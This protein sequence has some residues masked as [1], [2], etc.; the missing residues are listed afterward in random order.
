M[1]RVHEFVTRTPFEPGDRLAIATDLP[2][3]DVAMLVASLV[4]Q[5][6]AAPRPSRASTPKH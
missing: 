3:D 2:P 6:A 4:G 1:G 5:T